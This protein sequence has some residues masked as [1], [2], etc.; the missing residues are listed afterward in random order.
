MHASDQCH[1]LG[2]SGVAESNIQ[3]LDNWIKPRS[4]QSRHIQCCSD[5]GSTSPGT[6]FA[7]FGAAVMIKRGHT[8]QSR[9]L[10]RV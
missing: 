6:T 1:L 9:N 8:D 7:S 10:F 3:L 4:D 2:F 5:L